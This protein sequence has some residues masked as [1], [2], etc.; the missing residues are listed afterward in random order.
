MFRNP[1]QF[2]AKNAALD[3]ILET[4]GLPKKGNNLSRRAMLVEVVGLNFETRYP[5]YQQGLTTE[6][7]LQFQKD[8]TAAGLTKWE[9]LSPWLRKEPGHFGS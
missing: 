5:H 2:A 6:F 7:W 8:V 3:Q 4:L 9:Q 1:K